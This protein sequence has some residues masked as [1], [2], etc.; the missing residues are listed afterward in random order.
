MDLVLAIAP[1]ITSGSKSFT[2]SDGP[3]AVHILSVKGKQLG[4]VAG[5]VFEEPV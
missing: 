4:K 1:V 5:A 3:Y 2:W